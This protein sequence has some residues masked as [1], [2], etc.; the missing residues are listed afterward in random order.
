MIT[1]MTVATTT[2]YNRPLRFGNCRGPGGTHG[3]TRRFSA[4]AAGVGGKAPELATE[5]PVT[6]SRSRYD[7][8]SDRRARTLRSVQRTWMRLI[9]PPS[10]HL[11]RCTRGARPSRAAA[12]GRVGARRL[13]RPV[14][15]KPGPALAWTCRARART[16]S[17]SS[18][19]RRGACSGAG[20]ALAQ[21]GQAFGRLT[22]SCTGRR[23]E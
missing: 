2:L 9:A 8:L 7:S 18:E 11:Q 6:K 20:S 23:G 16:T 22:E 13:G 17:P 14:T 5:S 3:L 10:V 4:A 1:G 12:G 15:S 19:R 21:L